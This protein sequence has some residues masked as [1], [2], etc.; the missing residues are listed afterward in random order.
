MYVNYQV[1]ITTNSGDPATGAT[2]KLV[3]V[4][5]PSLQKCYGT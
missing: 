5:D 1:N 2:V 3:N 4:A